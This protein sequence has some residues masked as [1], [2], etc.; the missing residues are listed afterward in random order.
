M[1]HIV[2]IQT[3]VRDP[4]AVAN[5][6]QRLSLPSPVQRTVQLFSRQETGLA[7]ELPGWRYP[8]VCQLATGELRYDNYEGRW[9]GQS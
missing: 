3:Q 4:V 8:V 2:Q 5:A 9:K 7:V 6:C 1:S